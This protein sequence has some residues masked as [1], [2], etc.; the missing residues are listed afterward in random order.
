MA[1]SLLVEHSERHSIHGVVV[2]VVVVV[3]VVAELL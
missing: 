1:S 2:I 3:V